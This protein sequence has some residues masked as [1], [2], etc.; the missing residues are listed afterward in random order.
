MADTSGAGTSAA[1]EPAGPA[2]SSLQPGPH[3]PLLSVDKTDAAPTSRHVLLPVDDTD[4]SCSSQTT[5][6]R[7]AEKLLGSQ[8]PEQGP[9]LLCQALPTDL[10]P[11][12]PL[13]R[14]QDSQ[15]AIEWAIAELYKPGEPSTTCAAPRCVAGCAAHG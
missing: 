12:S 3:R 10:G 9:T 1:A 11:P 2:A 13:S 5:C 14:S 6:D 8:G 7:A 4:V 15:R